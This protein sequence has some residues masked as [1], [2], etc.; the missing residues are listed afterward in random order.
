LGN[1]LGIV[2]ALETEL[3]QRE[4]GFSFM[5]TASFMQLVGFLSRCYGKSGNPNSHALLRIAKTIT[6]LETHLQDQVKLETLTSIANMS[7]RSLIR[8]FQA[9]TGHSPIGYR[10]QQRVNRAASLLREDRERTVTEIAFDCGFN[11]SNYFTRQFRKAMGSSPS[12]YRKKHL[13]AGTVRMRERE[14]KW[15]TRGDYPHPSL[16]HEGRGFC[17]SCVWC[18]MKH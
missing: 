7:K 8:A 16:S 6:Y 12:S 5:S 2:E 14:L 13:A 18:L 1:A 10:I 17:C 3:K 15:L 11:D 9:A 4:A